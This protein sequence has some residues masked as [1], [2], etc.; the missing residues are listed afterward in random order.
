MQC[1]LPLLCVLIA[2]DGIDLSILLGTLVPPD[3]LVEEDTLWTFDSLLR[4]R[5][6]VIILIIVYPFMP[7][8]LFILFICIAGSNRGVEYGQ[9]SWPSEK[10]ISSNEFALVSCCLDFS[11]STRSA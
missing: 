6:I 2:Q 10:T 8:S 7:C 1:K 9:I 4:V 5:D 3:M 11:I